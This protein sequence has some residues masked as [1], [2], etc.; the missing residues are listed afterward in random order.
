MKEGRPPLWMIIG[1]YLWSLAGF[2]LYGSVFAGLVF[3]SRRAAMIAIGAFATVLAT[4]L[5][6]SVVEYRR[7]MRRPWPDVPPL[8]DDDDD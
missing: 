1:V 5:L 4:H 6:V 8:F 3:E 7:T 2:V